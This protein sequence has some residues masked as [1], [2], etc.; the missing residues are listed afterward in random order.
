MKITRAELRDRLLADPEALADAVI[1]GLSA[2]GGE[3][4]W[5][6]ETI[7]GV[8][9]PF[10]SIVGKTGMPWVGSTGDSAESVNAWR[11]MTPA[12]WGEICPECWGEDCNCADD[13]LNPANA[14]PKEDQK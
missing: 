5:G 6:A 7:E 8:L 1:D 12:T 11:R 14:T 13:A 10:H 9:A 4:E 3:M 2:A